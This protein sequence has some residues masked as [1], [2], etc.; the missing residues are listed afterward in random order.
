MKDKKDDN[1]GYVLT[2]DDADRARAV[3]LISFSDKNG[4]HCENCYFFEKD[5]CDHPQIQV[6]VDGPHQCC[7]EWIDDSL[8]RTGEK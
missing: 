3:D 7:N 5:F 2:G 4:V 1:G 6:K 8:I